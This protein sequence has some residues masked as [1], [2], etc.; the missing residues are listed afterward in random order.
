MHKTRYIYAFKFSEELRPQ[1]LLW[2]CYFICDDCQGYGPASEPV[3]SLC[4]EHDLGVPGQKD[5]HL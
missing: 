1:V 4:F 2:Q 3:S 5:V